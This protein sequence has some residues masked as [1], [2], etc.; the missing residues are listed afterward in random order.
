MVLPLKKTTTSAVLSHGTTVKPL[1]S[2]PPNKWTPSVKRVLSLVPK[3]TSDVSLYN[4]P[5]FS[6][7]GN[8]FELWMASLATCNFITVQSNR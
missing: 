5:L 6:R 2:R 3:R 7:Q 8:E 1:L 4:E